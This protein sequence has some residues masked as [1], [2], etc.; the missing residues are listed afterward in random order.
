MRGWRSV[1]GGWVIACALL[2][3]FGAYAASDYLRL[4]EANSLQELK[5]QV[6]DVPGWLILSDNPESPERCGVLYQDYFVG[7]CRLFMHHANNTQGPARIAA[8]LYNF[9]DKDAVVHIRKAGYAGPS[10]DY[11]LVGKRASERY[12]RSFGE[13]PL[14]VRA[15]S[16]A[17]LDRKMQENIVDTQQLVSAIYDIYSESSL[18]IKVVIADS[19]WSSVQDVSD[20]LPMQGN[21]PRGTFNVIE[22]HIGYSGVYSWHAGKAAITLATPADYVKGYDAITGKQVV[23]YG[24]YGVLYNV[25]LDAE[26]DEPFQVYFNPR[27]GAIGTALSVGSSGQRDIVSM[28]ADKTAFGV[29]TNRELQAVTRVVN[30]GRTNIQFMPPGSANLPI[31]L[32]IAMRNR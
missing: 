10:H 14:I 23:N 30:G 6:H 5:V 19:A 2:T 15:H 17:V 27:G 9:S 11:R 31:K 20:I 26:L 28:P 8:V 25:S 24:N 32:I 18:F 22:K 16:S 3:T 7:N 1:V 13:T 21:T 12:M 29:G 4:D